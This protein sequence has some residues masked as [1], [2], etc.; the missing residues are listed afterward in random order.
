MSIRTQCDLRKCQ[1]T[2]GIV[3]ASVAHMATGT[4]ISIVMPA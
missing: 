4:R 3:Q 1:D 2:G